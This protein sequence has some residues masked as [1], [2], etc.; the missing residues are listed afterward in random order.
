LTVWIIESVN[1]GS[2]S[3]RSAALDDDLIVKIGRRGRGKGEF[4]NPQGVAGLAGGG[5]VVTDSN[6]QCL[7]IFDNTGE[8]KLRF[9]ERG[10]RVGQLQ[11]PVGIAIF[12]SNGNIAVSDYDNRWISIFDPNGK[13]MSRIGHGKLLGPK[14]LTVDDKGLLYVVDNKASAVLVFQ[15]NGKLVHKFGSRGND[16]GQFAGP[17]FIAVNTKGNIIV[18]DFHNHCVKVELF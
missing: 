1:G 14:G 2:S 4:A 5:I 6:N 3:R 13:F 8:C 16:E 10:R 15:P 18:T 12:P 7:Q 17:H 11:R 9:G